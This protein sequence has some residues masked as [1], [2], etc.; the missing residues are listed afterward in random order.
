MHTTM[1]R[2]SMT[3]YSTAVGPSSRFRKFTT[4]FFRFFS[5]THILSLSPHKRTDEETK[6]P[7][8]HPSGFCPFVDTRCRRRIPGWTNT[9]RQPGDPRGTHGFASHPSGWF[10]FVEEPGSGAV[11][12]TGDTSARG[13]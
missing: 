8:S 2:A 7:I 10:A 9:I 13:R 12:V 6:H 5:M 11:R 1:I 3:A 4:A